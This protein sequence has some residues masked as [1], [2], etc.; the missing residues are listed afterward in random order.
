[1]AQPYKGDRQTVTS[2]IPRTMARRLNNVLEVT[3]ETRTDL[4]A[5][6]LEEYVADAEADLARDQ[7][8][9]FNKAS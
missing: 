8:A 2:K 3:A 7:E 4:I 6:L 5:R 9:L 1:M